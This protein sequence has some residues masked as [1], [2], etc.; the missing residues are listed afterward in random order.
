[1]TQRIIISF[2]SGLILGCI[3]MFKFS[4]NTNI[5]SGGENALNELK[6]VNKT[7]LD[8]IVKIDSSRVKF[9]TKYKVLKQTAVLPC[10]TLVKRIVET[11][12]TIIK[13]DSLE[14][15]K[16]KQVIAND[17]VIFDIQ[18]TEINTLK[19]EVKRQRRKRIIATS[20]GIITAGF[21]SYLL[22]TK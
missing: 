16:L 4:D 20:L 15:I 18:K 17:S 21:A 9:I 12:D 13:V 8:T 22:I 1:M 6:I 7:I 19:K 2:I 5:N 10:D 14:I 3:I 11:C